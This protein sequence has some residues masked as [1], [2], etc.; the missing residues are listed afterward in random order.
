MK[1]RNKR[2]ISVFWGLCAARSAR[3][4][5]KSAKIALTLNSRD[6]TP[7]EEFCSENTRRYSETDPLRHNQAH[8]PGQSE[9]QKPPRQAPRNAAIGLGWSSY[10]R[11]SSCLLLPI[12]FGNLPLTQII[13][14]LS[15]PI[16]DKQPKYTL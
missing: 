13:K 9:Q 2:G 15:H 4:S 16:L 10:P 12:W 14:L 7:E 8:F 11:V 1:Q 6:S 3:I 5:A